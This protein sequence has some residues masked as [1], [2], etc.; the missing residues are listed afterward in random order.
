[1]FNWYSV[2]ASPEISGFR[3]FLQLA[4]DCER[5]DTAPEILVEI[6]RATAVKDLPELD[7]LTSG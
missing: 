4:P 7:R 2:A 3:I 1:V 5:L 6:I